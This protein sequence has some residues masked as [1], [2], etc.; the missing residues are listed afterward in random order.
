MYVPKNV[1]RALLN[2]KHDDHHNRLNSVDDRNVCQRDKTKDMGNCALGESSA[3][4]L[5]WE[6]LKTPGNISCSDSSLLHQ[7]VHRTLKLE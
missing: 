6:C 4:A 1:I 2:E 5:R 7:E 3:S